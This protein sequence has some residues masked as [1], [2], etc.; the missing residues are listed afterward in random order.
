MRGGSGFFQHGHTYLGHPVA[1][2][3]ALAVQ[4]VIRDH[5]LLAQVK[6]RGLKLQQALSS[7]FSSMPDTDQYLGDLRGEDYFGALRLSSRR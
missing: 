4:N 1:C 5:Q 3:A 6:S 7:A 2:A